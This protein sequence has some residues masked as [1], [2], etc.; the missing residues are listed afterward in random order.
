MVKRWIQIAPVTLL[1]LGAADA[2]AEPAPAAMAL[3]PFRATY[4]VEYRGIG[5][6]DIQFTLRRLDQPGTFEYFSKVRPS[7]LARIVISKDALES[8]VFRVAD[9]GIRPLEYRLEDGRS[10]TEDDVSLDF[11]WEAGKATGVED[12]EPVEIPLAPGVQD[13]MSIQIEVI[14]ALAEGRE[15]GMIPMIDGDKLKEYTYTRERTERIATPIG[16]FETVIYA[17]TRTG[18]NRVSRFW[19]APELG[20]VPVRGEQVRKGKV[21]TVMQISYLGRLE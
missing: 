21:E 6:G 15:P 12:D 9:G 13:R 11:N 19:Y 18:S 10:A 8:S 4:E 14:R 1:A 2:L 7:V 5:A 20:Y 3:Q 16:S 17:S